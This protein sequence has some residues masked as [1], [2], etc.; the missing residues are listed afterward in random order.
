[1]TEETE[2]D[3]LWRVEHDTDEDPDDVESDF[4]CPDVV[5]DDVRTHDDDDDLELTSTE[6]DKD[7]ESDSMSLWGF[8]IITYLF[9]I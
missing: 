2:D 4:L 8:T 1:M 9:I 6:N 3:F 5:G 7:L